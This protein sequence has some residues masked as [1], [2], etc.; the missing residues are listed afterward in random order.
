MSLRPALCLKSQCWGWIWGFKA[1]L[2]MQATRCQ[3]CGPKTSSAIKSWS[4]IFL[5]PVLHS[6]GHIFVTKA[7]QMPLSQTF[8]YKT[9]FADFK[10]SDQILVLN[11]VDLNYWLQI[12]PNG[13]IWCTHLA[14]GM[15]I[16]HQGCK[17]VLSVADLA[18]GM[19]IWPQERS[20]CLR[21]VC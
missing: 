15:C 19:Q 8:G 17:L 5:K 11:D 6:W 4:V 3:I 13:W 12:W 18:S 16:W 21:D 20:S 14:S 2:M 10:P 7:R 1:R 9:R